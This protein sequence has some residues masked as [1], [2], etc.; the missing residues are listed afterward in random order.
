MAEFGRV[1]WSVNAIFLHSHKYYAL[2]FLGNN[3]MFPTLSQTW[4]KQVNGAESDCRSTAE[5]I[6]IFG[7]VLLTHKQIFLF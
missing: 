7:F 5:E 2:Y 4:M 1:L 6:N 3:D